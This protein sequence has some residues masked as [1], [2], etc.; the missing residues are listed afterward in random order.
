MDHPDDPLKVS[1]NRRVFDEVYSRLRSAVT[2][3]LFGP[4]ERFVER[5]LTKRLNVSRTPLRE[6]LKRLEQEGLVVCYP[7]RGCFVRVPSLEEASQAYEMRR[8]AE[9]MAGELA[10]RR[11]TNAELTAIARVVDASRA[12]LEAG[13]RRQMLLRNNQ[14]HEL[15]A[16]AARNVF[17]EQ[18]LKMLWGYVDL[19]RGQSWTETDRAFQTQEEHEAI[20]SALMKREVG[21]ARKLNERHVENAWSAVASRFVNANDGATEAKGKIDGSAGVRKKR[22]T[23]VKRA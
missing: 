8:V 7:H 6:A 11:A 13:D 9:G 3:G 4:G 14:F 1:A 20:L 10:V 23:F 5:N 15:Q 21:Q 2:T 16:R 19:L 12:D 18:Q 17:L 22:G